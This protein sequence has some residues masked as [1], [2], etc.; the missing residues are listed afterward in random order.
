PNSAIESVLM[1]TRDDFILDPP[2]YPYQRLFARA[3]HSRGHRPIQLSPL[4]QDVYCSPVESPF[5]IISALSPALLV[6]ALAS[7]PAATQAGKPPDKP[8]APKKDEP[9]EKARR[10]RVVSD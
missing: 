1:W 2:P 8:E 10:K 3:K 7:G 5:M 4:R 9:K 6:L